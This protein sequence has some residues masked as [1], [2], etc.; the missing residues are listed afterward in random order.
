MR[1]LIISVI[2]LVALAAL[3]IPS[4]AM[5]ADTATFTGQGTTNGKLNTEICQP[6][7][8]PYVLFIYQTDKNAKTATI[9]VNGVLQP[10]VKFGNGTFKYTADWALPSNLIGNVTATS[11]GTSKNPRLLI[12]HGCGTD[13]NLPSSGTNIDYPTGTGTSDS[14]VEGATFT[15]DYTF[16]TDKSWNS[17]DDPMGDGSY[18]THRM[19]KSVDLVAVNATPI[20]GDYTGKLVGY[21]FTGYGAKLM[22]LEP[23]HWLGVEDNS[24]PYLYHLELRADGIGEFQ[25]HS[26][27]YSNLTVVEPVV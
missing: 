1:K 17:Y 4:S 22:N 7:G 21:Q 5:A 8:K 9:T 25:T 27:T 10:M 23:I 6:D 19:T 12:S 3:L 14:K 24:Y 26:E 15:A 13:T 2:S 11:D 20:I 18:K 16:I